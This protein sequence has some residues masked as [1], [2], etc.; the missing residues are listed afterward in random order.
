MSIKTPELE[1]LLLSH[2]PDCK[3]FEDHV[4]KIKNTRM[5]IGCLAYYPVFLIV[6]LILYLRF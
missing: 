1:F 3:K 2:H 6:F 5:C 4:I